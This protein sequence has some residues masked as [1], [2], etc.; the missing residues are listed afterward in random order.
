MLAENISLIPAEPVHAFHHI[1]S[2]DIPESIPG[3]DRPTHTRIRLRIPSEYHHEPVISRL[4]SYHGL[5]IKFH[6]ANLEETAEE[7][8]FDLE[9]YGTEK[10]LQSAL[11]YLNDLDIEI[12]SNSP[13]PEEETW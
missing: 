2:K 12:W 9:L 11:V 1:Q 10:Q 5:T 8:W 13:D 7:G 4:I 3:H 6:A